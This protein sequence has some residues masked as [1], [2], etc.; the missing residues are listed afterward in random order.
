MTAVIDPGRR[1]ALKTLVAG[2]LVP[3][4]SGLPGPAGAAH[5]PRVGLALGSGGARGLAHV[6]VFEVLEE[7]G[8]TP[9][10]IAGSSIGAIMGALYAAGLSSGDIH[11]AIDTLT[12]AHDES[13]FDSLL[14]RE[15]TR[16]IKFVEPFGAKGGLMK[17]D[18]FV[19]FLGETAGVNRFE[20]LKIPL[21]V[22]ATNFWERRMAV[23]D[24]GEIWP[25]VQGSMAMPGLFS[26]VSLGDKV[27]VDGGLT[28]P[29][30]Y[31]LLLEDCDITIA[32]DVLGMR[33]PG[34]GSDNGGG[35]G[36]PSYFDNSFNTF[37][38]MQ[39]SILEEKLR[40]VRPDILIRP[41]ISNVRVLEFH[42][43]ESI[44]EQSRPATDQLRS[45]LKTLLEKR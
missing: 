41:K 14:N 13:W 45:E 25:A 24:S 36:N 10:R 12:V 35:N 19:K 20:E 17:S 22:V 33:E 31:D 4:L 27:L 43:F 1:R 21:Q 9:H 44:F 32:V 37:Q 7:L 3:A 42:R 23:F 18:A 15:W 40:R 38:I 8:V 26:P 29:V 30:P 39:F 6:L 5:A 16:W 11:D 34:N 2:A 28:N